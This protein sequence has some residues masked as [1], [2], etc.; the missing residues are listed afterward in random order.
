MLVS[1]IIPTYNRW[2][3]LQR[4][5]ESVLNQTF[6]DWECIIVN[7]CSTQPYGDFQDPRITFVNLPVN[8]RKLHNSPCA[9]GL[10]RN[11]GIKIAKG[12]YL[13]FLDDD[14]WWEPNKLEL[15]L[16]EMKKYNIDFCSTNAWIHNKDSKHV[17]FTYHIKPI[18]E[19]NDIRRDNLITNSSVVIKKTLVES[20]GC[21]NLILYEDYDLWKRVMTKTNCLYL[22][23]QLLH[24]DGDHG[25]GAYYFS[26]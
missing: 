16:Q 10:T 7:D 14:D 2:K 1:I 8:M 24:Y 18:L 5:V 4:A 21:F 23:A 25:D 15:Q 3:Y 9:Q 12:E 22:E 20:V 19:L 11:E 6:T 17:Y 13:A 26:I